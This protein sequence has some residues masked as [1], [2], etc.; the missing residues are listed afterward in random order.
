MGL[1]KGGV[2]GLFEG[3]DRET[4]LRYFDSEEVVEHYA[5][6][7]GRVGLWRSEEKIF[8]RVFSPAD[9]ILE[10]GCGA[11]R[12]SFGLHELGFRNLLGVDY[13]RGMVRRARQLARVL[14]YPVPFRVGDATDLEFGEGVF[15]GAIF[16]FN[17]IMQIPGSGNRQTAFGEVF[18]VLRPGAW[19]VFTTHDRESPR[20]RT[21]WEREKVRWRKERQ[22][23]ELDEFGDRFEPTD[24][25]D[26][27][28]HVPS[29]EE[30]RTVVK[31]AGFR[32]EADAPRSAL[33]NESPEVRE[34]SDECRFWVV[35]KPEAPAGDREAERHG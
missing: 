31:N 22:K 7:A 2:C 5:R 3:M 24:L 28:I 4:V 35:R 15:D 32:I 8:R 21:F 27:F 19:F 18:R 20:H 17:G 23:P 25:G 16:G 14:E 30:V 12:I 6:A 33:A 26:L 13:A 10:L 29:V 9:S 34:F 11:G 1:P